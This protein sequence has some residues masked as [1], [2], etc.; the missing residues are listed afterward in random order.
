M[1]TKQTQS[2]S[3]FA[4]PQTRRES[5]SFGYTRQP[6]SRYVGLSEK[7][8]FGRPG[9]VHLAVSRAARG[10]GAKALESS[11]VPLPCRWPDRKA[12]AGIAQKKWQ[13][14]HQRRWDRAYST[15]RWMLGSIEGSESLRAIECLVV[16]AHCF[17]D[18]NAGKVRHWS[19]QER[20]ASAV[21]TLAPSKRQLAA[22]RGTIV[23]HRREV[24]AADRL[25]RRVW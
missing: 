7:W 8:W 2:Q 4:Y 21:W 18:E 12:Q 1:P 9:K 14:C 3:A 16:D 19:P 17:G 13:I 15:L 5:A 24:T 11:G 23:S 20:P 10:S 6:S 22:R 25:P